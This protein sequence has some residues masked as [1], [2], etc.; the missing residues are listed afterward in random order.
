MNKGVYMHGVNYG[1]DRNY[2]PKVQELSL[3][4]VLTSGA[5]LSLRQQGKESNGGF[6]GVDYV[7]LCDYDK[8]LISNGTRGTRPYNAFYGYI[9]PAISLVFEKGKFEVIEPSIV[10][11]IFHFEDCYEKM[12]K[13]GESNGFYSDM[14]DEVF[15]K[16]RVSLE[17]M[18]G[19]TVPIEEYV[20]YIEMRSGKLKDSK[21]LKKVKAYVDELRSLLEYEGYKARLLDVDSL[22]ELTEEKIE[23]LVLKH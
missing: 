15:A 19:V 18:Y 8:R 20:K 16:D 12:K 7:S 6:N 9:R 17:H 4:K 3:C 11:N 21:R 14:P 23:G 10:E 2:D 13:Y 5:L 22:D 1:Y